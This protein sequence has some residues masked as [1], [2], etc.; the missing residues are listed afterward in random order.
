MVTSITAVATV[1]SGVLS[2]DANMRKKG[3]TNATVAFFAVSSV[4]LGAELVGGLIWQLK[5]KE[6]ATSHVQNI[7]N[8]AKNKTIVNS[9]AP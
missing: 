7:E 8:Q 5:D 4:L 6:K 2:L 9:P 1:I 3:N